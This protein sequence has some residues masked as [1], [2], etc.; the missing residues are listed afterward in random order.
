MKK[1]VNGKVV[2]IKNIEL[3]EMAQEGEA[4]GAVAISNTDSTLGDNN[5]NSDISRIIKMYNVF[6]KSMPYPLYAIEEDIKYAT[7]GSLIKHTENGDKILMFTDGGLYV[8]INIKDMQAIHIVNNSWSVVKLDSI[9]KDNVNMDLYKQHPAYETYVWLL[10]KILNRDSKANYYECFMGDF[11]RACN[12]D[13]VII[14]WE[15]QNILKMCDVPK[16]IEIPDNT[17]YNADNEERYIMDIY[18]SGNLQYNT[19]DTRWNIGSSISQRQATREVRRYA[20]KIYRKDDEN[21]ITQCKVEWAGALFAGIYK[22]K[23]IESMEEFPVYKAVVIGNTVVYEVNN[24]IYIAGSLG[25][26]EIANSA[27]IVTVD[28]SSIYIR[29]TIEVRDVQKIVIY[30]YEIA[31]G[32]ARVC[33]TKYCGVQK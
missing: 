30:K 5:K 23:C 17:I 6:Y 8:V 27:S 14:G 15:L 29:R 13:P 7:L 31:N 12:N 3:F 19:G 16:E 24:R 10:S 25:S 20:Y 9:K 32:R 1:I 33:H 4:R 2:D 18:K 11:L 21:E 28:K 22:I 26:K